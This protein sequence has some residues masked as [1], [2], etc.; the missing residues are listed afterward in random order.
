MYTIYKHRIEHAPEING[1]ANLNYCCMNEYVLI[2][3]IDLLKNREEAE[4]KLVEVIINLKYY[5]DHWLRARLF[6]A[7]LQLIHSEAEK[8]VALT[9]D[10]D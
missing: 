8:S 1:I 7:N 4:V 3:F 2:Y 9:K 5:C 6:A 10:S